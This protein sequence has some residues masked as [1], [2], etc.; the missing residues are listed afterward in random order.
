MSL[1]IPV[2]IY[3]GKL[4]TYNIETEK[5]ILYATKSVS[6]KCIWRK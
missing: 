1:L 4:K 5:K 2:S 3:L 6:Y